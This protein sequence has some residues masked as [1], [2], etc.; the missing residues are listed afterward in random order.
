MT[1]SSKKYGADLL[2][3]SS[4]CLSA[5]GGRTVKSRA[6]RPQLF[7]NGAR[8]SAAWERGL[9]EQDQIGAVQQILGAAVHHGLDAVRS[10]QRP[11]RGDP[12]LLAQRPHAAEDVAQLRPI[13][14][15]RK[16]QAVGQILG[17]DQHQINAGL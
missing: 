8:A 11:G 6:R 9:S 10:G 16:P 15:A 5:S 12:A 17:A 3:G 7:R 13:K 4:V 14:F 2:S 1:T